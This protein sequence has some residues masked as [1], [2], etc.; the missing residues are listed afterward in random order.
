MRATRYWLVNSGTTED[1]FTSRLLSRYREWNTTEGEVHGFSQR[2]ASIAVG[3]ILIHRAVGSR[4]N[5]IVAVATVTGPPV[6]RGRGHWPW[7]LPRRLTFVCS[8]LDVA[9]PA[10]EIGIEAY[11]V[12]TYKEIDPKAG[13]R[14]EERLE[15]WPSPNRA[16]EKRLGKPWAPGSVTAMTLRGW[17]D[18]RDPMRDG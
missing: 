4:G 17:L 8:T 9:P 10:A 14:A 5:R 7:R 3:D 11:G 13:Q 16:R 6:D 1:P 2:P 18:A 15:A 12:R